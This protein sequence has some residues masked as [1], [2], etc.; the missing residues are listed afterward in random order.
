MKGDDKQTPHFLL[1]TYPTPIN[2]TFILK[3]NIIWNKS[4]KKLKYFFI[5]C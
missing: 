1:K 4:I 5:W 2:N 3:Y